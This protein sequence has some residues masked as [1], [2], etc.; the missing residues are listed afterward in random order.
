MSEPFARL[1]PVASRAEVLAR[2]AANQP[3]LAA[4]GVRSLELFGSFARDQAGPA[5]DVDFVVEFAEPLQVEHYFALRF[6]LEDLLGRRIDLAR[7]RALKP[8]YRAFVEPEL[9]RV[10]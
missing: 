3:E 7:K 6:L 1:P 9:I 8:T 2:L 4:L 5:S 10:A